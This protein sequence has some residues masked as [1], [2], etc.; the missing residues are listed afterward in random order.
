MKYSTHDIPPLPA[1]EAGTIG[2]SST[3]GISTIRLGVIKPM[4]YMS[5]KKKS[6]GLYKR[7]I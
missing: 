2:Q 1:L 6:I 4:I 3:D 7:I 5:S